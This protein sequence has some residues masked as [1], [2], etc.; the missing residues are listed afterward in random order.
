MQ[1]RAGAACDAVR[2]P[3]PALGGERPMLGR[4]P[5]ARG[6][7]EVEAAAVDQLVQ[8]RGDLVALRHGERA[9]GREVVLEVDDHQRLA[10]AAESTTG[11]GARMRR[12]ARIPLAAAAFLA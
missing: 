7:H 11:Y 6:D 3:R 12:R 10:L 8:P 5:V 9:A 1:L 4:V 2:R